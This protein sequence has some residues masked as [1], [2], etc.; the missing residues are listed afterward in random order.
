MRT[1]VDGAPKTMQ[2]DTLKMNARV[3]HRG[4]THVLS[5]SGCPELR[6]GVLSREVRTSTPSLPTRAGRAE[7]GQLVD[8]ILKNS[9]YRGGYSLGKP[10][11][12]GDA[13]TRGRQLTHARVFGCMCS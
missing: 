8:T 3:S 12:G 10:H 2:A 7:H 11:V 9:G 4:M 5:D 6:N 13:G 1:N